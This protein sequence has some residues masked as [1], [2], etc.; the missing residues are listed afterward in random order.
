MKIKLKR[1]QS[2]YIVRSFGK[3]IT[4][5]QYQLKSDA[6]HDLVPFAQFKK[7]E[8]HPWKSVLFGKLAG[9]LKVTLIH[10]CF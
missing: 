7:R 3:L 6:L 4:M 10:G 9:L 2:V 1:R 8:K 5:Q